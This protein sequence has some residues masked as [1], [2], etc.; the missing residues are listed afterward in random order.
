VDYF[1]HFPLPL[2]PFLGM[3]R[4]QSANV[5]HNNPAKTPNTKY[6]FFRANFRDKTN[7]Y[8]NINISPYILSIIPTKR[9][10]KYPKQQ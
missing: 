6:S 1:P 3:T 8:I 9:P 4:G 10:S 7:N 5:L 2:N